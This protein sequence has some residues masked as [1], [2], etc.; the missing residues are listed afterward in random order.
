MKILH[1]AVG[2][3]TEGDVILAEASRAIVIGFNAVPDE[4]V[5][6]IAD[7][8]GVDVRLYILF[9]GLPK[10]SAAMG[11]HA[12]T[13]IQEKTLGRLVVRQTFKSP[14]SARLP[15]AM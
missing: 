9:I 5:R 10:I 14:V 7:S 8:K 6:Q 15:A 12:G 3:I 13:E 2:G 4:H 1:A 11:R